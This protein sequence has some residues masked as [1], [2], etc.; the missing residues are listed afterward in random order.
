MNININVR[1][2]GACPICK[3]TDNCNIQETLKRT[4]EEYSY[5]DSTME[6]VIFSCPKFSEK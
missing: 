1:G 2:N 6:I 5:E 4:L 3:H